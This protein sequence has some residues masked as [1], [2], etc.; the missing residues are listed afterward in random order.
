MKYR[1]MLT[2]ILAAALV[3]TTTACTVAAPQ[4]TEEATLGTFANLS[5]PDAQEPPASDSDHSAEE[6]TPA[7]QSDH[8][9]TVPSQAPETEPEKTEPQ[10]ER[11]LLSFVG[12][13]TLGAT[14]GNWY[15]GLGFIKTVGEDYDYP[16]QNVRTYF[17][18]DDLTFVNLEGV[19]GEAGYPTEKTFNFRGPAEYIQILT[20]S[21]VEVVT[22]ANNHSRDYGQAGYNSTV[23]ILNEAKLPFVERDSSRIFTTESGLTVGFYGLMFTLDKKDMAEEIANMRS[24]GAEIVVVACHWGSEHVYNAGSEQKKVA[25][26]AI[27][28]GADIVY[29]SHPHVLQPVEWYNGG[30]IYYSLG[31]FCFGGN[32]D[33]KDY[34]T[35]ILQQEIIRHPDGTVELGSLTAIPASISSI[36]KSNNYQPTPYDPGTPE[37]IRTMEKLGLG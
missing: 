16:F 14:A 1:K 13:C 3:L 31:N 19:L 32:T 15:T 34:D 29:G 17:E 37:Y 27:D 26:Y 12:D 22:L 36:T 33:P 21:S 28:C 9:G 11:F 18:N 30:V 24:Q 5:L 4:D 35:A 20:G 23:D 25:Y 2:L 7:A 8:S 10:E 6:S